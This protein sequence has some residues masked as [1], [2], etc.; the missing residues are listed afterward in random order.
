MDGAQNKDLSIWTISNTESPMTDVLRPLSLE[1]AW[2]EYMT[3]NG[4]DVSVSKLFKGLSEEGVSRKCCDETMA[5]FP[6]LELTW[7]L[8]LKVFQQELQF[9]DHKLIASA[10]EDF[11]LEEFW[12]LPM[13]TY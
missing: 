6:L 5:L 9:E 10:A 11:Q 12:G 3:R 7:V 4:K 13:L 2:L 1:K 8:H